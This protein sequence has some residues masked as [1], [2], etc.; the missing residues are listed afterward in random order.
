MVRRRDTE[1]GMAEKSVGT[2]AVAHEVT[3]EATVRVVEEVPGGVTSAA[4]RTE[5]FVSAQAARAWVLSHATITKVVR[6]AVR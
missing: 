4:E 5:T 3:Y 6:K 1:D 2:G